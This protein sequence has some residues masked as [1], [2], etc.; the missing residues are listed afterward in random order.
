[1]TRNPCFSCILVLPIFFFFAFRTSGKDA[2]SHPNVMLISFDT[3]RADHLRCYGYERSTSSF[4][5]QLAAEGILFERC[6]SQSVS[7]LPSHMSL[8][9]S[10]YPNSHKVNMHCARLAEEKI[11]AAEIFR[12]NGYETV[13]IYTNPFLQ[14]SFGF[15]QGFDLYEGVVDEFRTQGF[16]ATKLLTQWAEKRTSDKPFFLFLHYNDA[17]APYSPP[18]GFVRHFDPDYEGDANGAV[19]TLEKYEDEEVDPRDLAHVQ[20]LYDDEIRYAD[21]ELA[22]SAAC[23]ESHGLLENT[24]IAFISDHGEEFKEH[25]RTKHPNVLYN[26]LIHVPLII[27]FPTQ[28]GIKP[29]R[30]KGMVKSLDVLPT[31]LD[32]AGISPGGNIHQGKSLLPAIREPSREE[33]TNPQVFT[34]AVDTDCVAIITENMKYIYY[35]HTRKEELYRLDQDPKEQKNLAK[36]EKA[37][38][39]QLRPILLEHLSSQTGGWHFRCTHPCVVI[40]EL[41]TD[42]VFESVESFDFNPKDVFHLNSQKNRIT[43]H[44]DARKAADKMDGLDFRV[45]DEAY[46]IRLLLE[47]ESTVGADAIFLGSRMKNPSSLPLVIEPE[48]TSD[49][50]APVGWNLLNMSR[51]RPTDGLF[52]WKQENPG[53]TQTF[54]IDKD[55]MK[56]LKSLGYFR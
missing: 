28:M 15:K 46:T 53:A 36:E 16:E 39:D 29:R 49:F 3:L 14:G 12:E 44:M 32:A 11:T 5:D 31:L 27:K 8:M 30:Y 21:A 41:V 17:H 1:M 50:L 35:P 45:K 26:E 34:E 43:F 23:M 7:T 4:L 52:L 19:E 42:G 51:K 13:G 20:S 38:C 37:T 25:G 56:R 22:K 48:N 33:S 40:G 24:I 6:Y 55:T 47:E 54:T 10:L 18:E 2:D 9:T